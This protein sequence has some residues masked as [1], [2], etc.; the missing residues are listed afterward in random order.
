MSFL[1]GLACLRHRRN[2]GR[3]SRW[4]PGAQLRVYRA[5]MPGGAGLH[6]GHEGLSPRHVLRVPHALGEAAAP[7]VRPTTLLLT[8][9]AG[10]SCGPPPP[11]GGAG[12]PGGVETLM[13]G[14]GASLPRGI[15]GGGG[16]CAT[17]PAHWAPPASTKS[18]PGSLVPS[19]KVTP[20]F[21]PFCNESQAELPKGK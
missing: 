15:D 21:C 13:R 9:R 16:A 14:L 6:G 1:A 5:R 17:A 11:P 3:A 4:E 8:F 7:H 12:A 2:A 20:S 19:A 18:G 10:P